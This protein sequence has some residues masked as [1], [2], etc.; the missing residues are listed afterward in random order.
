LPIPGV[1][2]LQQ[3]IPVAAN[4]CRSERTSLL[5]VGE[6]G[7]DPELGRF[8]LPPADPALA[9][10]NFTV[11]FVEAFSA[12][13]GANSERQP[14]SASPATRLVSRSGDADSAL[15]EV[16]DGAPVHSSLSD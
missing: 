6:L 8:A 5:S 12:A 10:G 4:L 13:I 16:L 14:A 15:I 1:W 9:Q 3:R 2:P 7:I 11:D